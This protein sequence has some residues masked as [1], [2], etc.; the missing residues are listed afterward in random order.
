MSNSCKSSMG[1]IGCGDGAV[2]QRGGGAEVQRSISTTCLVM[3]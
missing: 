3:K 1:E 2:V